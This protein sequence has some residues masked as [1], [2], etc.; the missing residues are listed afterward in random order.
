[1]FD[2][3]EDQWIGDEQ[4][5]KQTV[6]Y[7]NWW[8]STANIRCWILTDR[9]EKKSLKIAV[10]HESDIKL[11][12]I[13]NISLCILGITLRWMIDANMTMPFVYEPEVSHKIKTFQLFLQNLQPLTDAYDNIMMIRGLNSKMKRI[14]ENRRSWEEHLSKQRKNVE[15]GKIISTITTNEWD[16]YVITAHLNVH[17]NWREEC[18]CN[19]TQKKN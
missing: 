6:N 13:H 7:E 18:Q 10:K 15:T 19:M 17:A 11:V 16:H 4:K 2:D 8:S 3:T 5:G 12:K 9:P 1:M 14:Y